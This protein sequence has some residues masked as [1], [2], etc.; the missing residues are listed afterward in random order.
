MG[1]ADSH[2]QR[3]ELGLKGAL[4]VRVL[5]LLVVGMSVGLCRAESGF[6]LGTWALSFCVLFLSFCA[7]GSGEK[8]AGARF[9]EPSSQRHSPWLFQAFSPSPH[10][11]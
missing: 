8:E 6:G 7:R 1:A 2:R 10:L 3:R 5:L 11:L 4:T 9:H